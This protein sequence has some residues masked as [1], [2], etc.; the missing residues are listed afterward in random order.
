MDKMSRKK[1]PNFKQWDFRIVDGFISAFSPAFIITMINQGLALSTH[2]IEFLLH[3]IYH[4]NKLDPSTFKTKSQSSW[5]KQLKTT[6]KTHSVSEKW[7]NQICQMKVY[8]T[9]TKTTYMEKLLIYDTPQPLQTQYTSYP[10]PGNQ[11]TTKLAL[12]TDTI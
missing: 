11:T 12:V 3:I 9:Y 7:T 6:S 1:T 10:N 4:L 2:V 8:Q 5:Y